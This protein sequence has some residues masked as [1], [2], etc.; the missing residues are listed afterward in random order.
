MKDL[1]TIASRFRLFCHLPGIPTLLP[2][3]PFV[4]EVFPSLIRIRS[5]K[6]FQVLYELSLTGV[7]PLEDFTI[8]QEWEK[9]CIEVTGISSTGFVHYV[10]FPLC[11][12]S[13]ILFVKKKAPPSFNIVVNTLS[14]DASW[15][16]EKEGEYFLLT[17]RVPS[18]RICIPKKRA[19]LS[20]GCHKKQ[21]WELILRRGDIE[22]IFPLW[23]WAAQTSCEWTDT[24]PEKET[25]LSCFATAIQEKNMNS[26]K[27]IFLDM[28]WAG[29]QGMFV[30]QTEDS[31]YLGYTMPA[32]THDIKSSPLA[33]FSKSFPLFKSLFFVEEE[34]T[35]KFF[36]ALLPE[37]HCGRIKEMNIHDAMIS[38]EWT[39]KMVR[40]VVIAPS[41][42]G[43]RTLVFP[44]EIR[45]FC[46]R[47]LL[48]KTEE[49]CFP[50][51]NTL[52]SFEQGKTY[53]LDNFEK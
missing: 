13:G 44:R 14:V 22:E 6:T 25:M 48:D 8:I 21:D 2:T 30:P 36:P 17:K 40:R 29:L 35:W 7:G 53:L 41:F 50:S 51:N 34:T 49:K 15:K 52:I 5:C 1:I 26:L 28:F 39:K 23:F 32:F 47:N 33:L 43:E 16:Q 12:E 37:F 38:L 42:S 3:S 10:L 18:K 9:G 19:R 45:K 31:Q 4:V 20:L 27:S 46:M 11:E 24:L